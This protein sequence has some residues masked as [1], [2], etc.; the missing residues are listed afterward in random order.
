MKRFLL[1]LLLLTSCS[2]KE[3]QLA[4]TST[5]PEEIKDVV[6]V[7][8]EEDTYSIWTDPC[9]N[10]DWYF[11]EDLSEVWR[12]QICM[13]ECDDPKTV[14]FEGE[15]EQQLECNPTQYL[16]EKDAPCINDDGEPG[17]QDKVCV[18]G[19]IQIYRLYCRLL[20]GGL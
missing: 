16:I 15:C 11:C 1:V 4:E 9:V 7:V 5:A 12:K 10:C 18:K 17:F 13:N 8:V 14:V 6:D 2:N 19:L 20:R 3:E